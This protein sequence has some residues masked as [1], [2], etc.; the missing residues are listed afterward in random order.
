MYTAKQLA[1]QL[2]KMN[3]PRDG[4]LLVHSS[5]KSMGEISGGPETVLDVLCECVADGLLIMPT[6]SWDT[7]GA[8]NPCF[9]PAVTPCCT[10]ILGQLLLKREGSIRTVH[11]T[12][13]LAV[14]GRNAEAFAAGEHLMTT[15][16]GRRG[17]MGKLLDMNAKIL[18]LGCGLDKNTFLHGVEEWMGIEN[19]LGEEYTCFLTL[20]DGSMFIGSMQPHNAPVPDV[21]VNYAKMTEPFLQLG[22]AETHRLGDARCYLCDCAKMARI[23]TELLV[24]L[25]DVF[26][27]GEPVPQY[28]VDDIGR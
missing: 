4:V 16:C 27:D 2:K 11:P 23:T 20:N 25:P 6:H 12:H 9:D 3:I 19:R 24:V 15:P 7:V 26:L 18:F 13:S 14:W 17:C 28:L 8:D 10:G 22:A 1:A 21:S 5:F